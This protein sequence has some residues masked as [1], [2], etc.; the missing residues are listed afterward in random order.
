MILIKKN[1]TV[2]LNGGLI[3]P[4]F[5]HPDIETWISLNFDRIINVKKQRSSLKI[6]DFECVSKIDKNTEIRPLNG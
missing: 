2:N 1:Q 6:A 4:I 5:T 3:P